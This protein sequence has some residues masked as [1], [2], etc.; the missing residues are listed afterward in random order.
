[1]PSWV[2]GGG[3]QRLK[4]DIAGAKVGAIQDSRLGRGHDPHIRTSF[5]KYCSQRLIWL[6]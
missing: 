3:R 2:R 1:M 6:V 4:A 5:G